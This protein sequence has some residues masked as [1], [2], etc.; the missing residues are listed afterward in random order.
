M[1]E[2]II[3]SMTSYPARI[4]NVPLSIFALFNTQTLPPDEVHLF[5]SVEEFPCK[6][7]DLPAA[8]LIMSHVG[9]VKIHW[10]GE[11]TYVHKRHEI[12]K[13]VNEGAVFFIDD[14]VLYNSVLIETVMD[15]HEKFPN[16]IVCYN[17]YDKHRYN[18]MHI[19][20]GE[21]APKGGPYVNEYRWCGQSMIP[22]QVY[23]KDLLSDEMKDIRKTA[24]YI[25]DECWFQPWVVYHDIPI[26]YLSFGWGTDLSKT[27]GKSSGLVGWSHKKLENG[28]EYRDMWLNS[29]LSK[30]PKLMEKYKRL[31]HYGE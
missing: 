16:S 24:S 19:Q 26:Y 18:G 14:D 28:Y 20:Y 27:A 25:S 10:V 4:K 5:L 8:L 23:P 21:P 29:T 22:A 9:M 7:D 3:V 12:F 31:Y 11:N 6:E 30:F 15:V 17:R 2:R 1:R 13:H